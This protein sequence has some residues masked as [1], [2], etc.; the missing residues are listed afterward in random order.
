MHS[1][2]IP[3]LCNIQYMVKH[4]IKIAQEKKL[5]SKLNQLHIA[6]QARSFAL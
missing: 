4:Q 3:N 1:L 2:Y 6:L 5:A